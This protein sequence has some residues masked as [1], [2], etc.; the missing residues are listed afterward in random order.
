MPANKTYTLSRDEIVERVRFKSFQ[1]EQEAVIAIP[2]GDILEGSLRERCG[3]ESESQSGQTEPGLHD[4][5]AVHE[6]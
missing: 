2:T 5:P 6:W 3:H 1:Q 4:H